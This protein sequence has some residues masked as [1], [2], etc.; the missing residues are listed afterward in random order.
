MRK[1]PMIAA[2]AGLIICGAA[3]A[4]NPDAG[5]SKAAICAACHGL[6]G[7]S[8]MPNYPNLKGQ[9]EQYIEKALRAYRDG[10]RSD[11]TM[12]PMAKPLSDG[13]IEDLAAYFSGL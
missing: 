5:K 7:I 11:P 8:V 9:K 1:Q 2:M 13:D 12:S 4:G 10:G 6:N 3:A